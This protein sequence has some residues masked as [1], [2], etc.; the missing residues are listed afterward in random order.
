MLRRS[1]I[2]FAI[3]F[4]IAW[5]I[6]SHGDEKPKAAAAP[7]GAVTGKVVDQS[8]RLVAGASVWGLAY[9][10]KYGPVHAGGDGRFRLPGLALDKPVTIWAEAPR[11]A[12]E[13]RDDVRIFP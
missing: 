3:V 10:K 1:V 6:A 5:A 9:Q 7:T 11:L 13:R 12:R 2:L 4:P 8:G